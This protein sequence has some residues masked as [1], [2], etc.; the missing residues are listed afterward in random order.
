[1][2]FTCWD[3][4]LDTVDFKQ[5]TNFRTKN[6]HL[7]KSNYGEHPKIF[8]V[9][10]EPFDTDFT[11]SKNITGIYECVTINPLGPSKPGFLNGV[12]SSNVI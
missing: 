9:K 10:Y 1:M 8:E 4:Y 7:N 6:M 12:R 11:R 2:R 3:K 5:V